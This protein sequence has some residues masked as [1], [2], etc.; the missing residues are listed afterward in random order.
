MFFKDLKQLLLTALCIFAVGLILF[1]VGICTLIWGLIIPGAILI[2]LSITGFVLLYEKTTDKSDDNKDRKVADVIKNH[3][4]ISIKDLAKELSLTPQQT[5]KRV[6][7]C[8][9]KKFLEDYTLR[10][11]VIISETQLDI[12]NGDSNVI[13]CPGCGASFVS[14]EQFPECPYCG[15]ICE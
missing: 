6:Y 11:D 2:G 10:G 9:K 15:R 3:T 1:I 7:S 8:I 4:K 14:S 13:N 5:T 12:E